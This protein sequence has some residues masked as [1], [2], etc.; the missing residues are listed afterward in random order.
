MITM[1]GQSNSTTGKP[2]KLARAIACLVLLASLCGTAALAHFKLNQNVRI[3]HV[4]HNDEGANLYLRLPLAYLLAGLL[5]PVQDD[6]LPKPAPFTVNR[7][8]DGAVMHIVDH[9]ALTADPMGLG[10]IATSDIQVQSDEGDLP[11]EVVAVRV[12]PIGTEPGFATRHEAKAAFESEAV[13]PPD[14]P[15]T[16]VGD[17]VVDVHLRYGGGPIRSYAMSHSFDPGLPEQ[18][19]TANLILDY[20]GDTI[21]TFR[22]TGLM[23]EP[24]Q[25]MQSSAAAVSTFV[26]EGIR[27]IL[28]GP[29]HVLFVLC[30][31]IGASGL[32]SLV[33]RVTGFTI[34][35][36]VTLILGFFGIAPSGAWF[37]P[38]VELAIAL[39]IIYAAWMAVSKDDTAPGGNLRAFAVT[40]G[41]GLLHGFGFSFML[42][43]ILKVDAPNVWQS[44]LAFNV[45]VEIGQLAIV[46]L[47][48]P[49]VV[50]LRRIPGRVWLL[51]RGVVAGCASII[52]MFWVVERAAYFL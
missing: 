36:T 23:G 27:H 2:R 4:V 26:V 30:M 33:E 46:V 22:A 16:Y 42:H 28:E 25:I 37:I 44:L 10:R 38:T 43:Q 1:M 39:S 9:R 19:K 17:A 32:W 48:W 21:R 52:A 5:G 14:A 45:G 34:G 40:S 47:V 8:E 35:H 31:I 13:F 3:H 18:E 12:H 51:S 50:V 41:I 7:L 15:E 24:V 49:I 29:D 20:R 11:L 6:G